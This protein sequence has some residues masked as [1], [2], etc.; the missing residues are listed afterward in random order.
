VESAFTIA[1]I[2]IYDEQGTPP[3]QA[4]LPAIHSRELLS[5]LGKLGEVE[6]HFADLGDVVF[7]T[8]FW[9]EKLQQD[10]GTIRRENAFA[11]AP[12]ELVMSGPHFY[13]ANPLNKTSRDMRAGQMGNDPLDLTVLPDNYLPR[14]TYRPACDKATYYGR[15]PRVRWPGEDI[16]VS[17]PVT[18]YYRHIN[19]EM[20]GATNERSLITALIPKGVAHVNSCISAAFMDVRTLLDFHAYTLSIV[21]DFYIKSTGAGH[22][23]QS[24]L[25]RLPVIDKSALTTIR[26]GLHIRALSLS[27]LTSPYIELWKECWRDEFKSEHWTNDSTRLELHFFEK[28][29]PQWHRDFALRREYTRRQALLEVDVLSA[30]AIGLTLDE[31]LT[32]YR[33]QFPVMRQYERDTWYDANGRIVFTA[34][35]GLVGVGL[36][37]K[38][39]RTEME[40]SVEYPDGRALKKRL[41]WEDVQPRD[42]KPQ[43]PDGARIKRPVM[44][45]T[46]P[47]GPVERV[48]EYVAP[49]GLADREGDYRIA[50]A[51]FERRA[52]LERAH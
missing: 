44:D 41:G 2:R 49:F 18:A 5:V 11:N 24:Y 52:A 32:I 47:G 51:E 9:N 26:Y 39:Q 16:Q 7:C 36:P 3:S 10:D 17:T 27:C 1:G 46:M 48:I 25:N 15:V 6:T 50:W 40:C 22:A 34:S 19:R 43:I 8:R 29:S 38:A 23:N 37:R 20:V 35:K 30:Q 4:R 28:L 45:D 33:V 14:S 42:G 31:L 13:V 12:D 21:A